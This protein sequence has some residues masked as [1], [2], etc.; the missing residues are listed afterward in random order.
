MGIERNGGGGE[1]LWVRMEEA[2]G[3]VDGG[4]G[5]YHG[6][7]SIFRILSVNEE[8][9]SR[10]HWSDIYYSRRV[11]KGECESAAKTLLTI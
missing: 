3:M 6:T 7:F 4:W 1:G 5:G 2:V 11:Q 10:R 9:H 8:S